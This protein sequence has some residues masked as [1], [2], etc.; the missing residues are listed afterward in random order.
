MMKE[1]KC[2][3]DLGVIAPIDEPTPWI[4][5]AVV[6]KKKNGK[7]R[8][9][10]DPHELNKVLL[11]VHYTLPILEEN[12]HE[13]G[14]SH[15]SSKTDL[16]LGYW[17]ITLDACGARY[18]WLRL[19][20]ALSVSSGIFQKRLLEGIF[21]LPGMIYIADDVIIHGRTVEEHD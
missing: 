1:L 6:A 10:I 19:P 13:L 4:N 9:C 2:L 20:F 11:R 17:H 7:L 14:Q 5:Q 3:T 16:A 21:D 8:I 18:R 15:I 12:L